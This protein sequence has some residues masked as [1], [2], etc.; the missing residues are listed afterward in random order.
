MET[1][2]E[3]MAQAKLEKTQLFLFTHNESCVF[4]LHR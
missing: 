1:G 3:H 2:K 4:P